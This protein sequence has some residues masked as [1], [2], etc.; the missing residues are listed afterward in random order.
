M[1]DPT[2]TSIT[3]LERVL[4]RLEGVH[5]TA[6]GYLARC[7]A[8]EDHGP[9]L[10]IREGDDGRVLLH[11]WAGCETSAIL[12]ALHLT[13]RGLFPETARVRGWP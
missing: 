3:A 8:H 13:W 6:G 7:P 11:C 1:S 5:A 4:G 2:A 12:A 9:S 10:S